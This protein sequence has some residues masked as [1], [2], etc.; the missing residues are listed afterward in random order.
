[1]KGKAGSEKL[2]EVVA[3]VK[4]LVVRNFRGRS[5]Y[6]LVARSTDANGKPILYELTKQY[7]YIGGPLDALAGFLRLQIIEF[8]GRD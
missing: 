1:V 8:S 6:A 3:E 4:L 5:G 7:T 2:D